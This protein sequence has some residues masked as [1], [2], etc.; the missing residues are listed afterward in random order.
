[1]QGVTEIIRTWELG[2][3]GGEGVERGRGEGDLRD[4]GLGWTGV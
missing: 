2:T 4:Q 3:D 1:M